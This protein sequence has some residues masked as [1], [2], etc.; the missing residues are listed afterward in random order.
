MP[1]S[2][3]L[4]DPPAEA[5][6]SR[7]RIRVQPETSLLARDFSGSGFRIPDT[8]PA[9][10]VRQISDSN[11][12]RRDLMIAPYPS[13]TQG[14]TNAAQP[15]WIGGVRELSG[16]L[17]AGT[18]V[19][20]WFI[21]SLSAEDFD[22]AGGYVAYSFPDSRIDFSALPFRGRRRRQRSA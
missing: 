4:V 3:P 8:A 13:R 22:L 9:L 2:N 6:R 1:T 12:H 11:L 16:A 21:P 15:A 5:G 14:P 17:F 19:D 10:V 7:A 20:Q 18:Q